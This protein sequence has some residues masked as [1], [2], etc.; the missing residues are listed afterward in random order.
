MLDLNL[1]EA[2]KMLADEAAAKIVPALEKSLHAVLDR[3][4]EEIDGLQIT[5][6]V[7]RKPKL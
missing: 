4:L 6:T 7:T 5:V 1:D 2:A 3:L